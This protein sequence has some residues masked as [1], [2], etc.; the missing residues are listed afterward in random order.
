MKAITFF[1]AFEDFHALKDVCLI[2]DLLNKHGY[3]HYIATSNKVNREKI[4]QIRKM[5]RF[6]SFQI[7]SV[8]STMR[9]KD[10]LILFHETWSTL[11]I[12]L[13]VKIWSFATYKR[14]KVIVKADINSSRVNQ[15]TV[16]KSIR[17]N[18]IVYT[19]DM[20]LYE[21]AKLKPLITAKKNC[22]RTL[23]VI[24]HPPDFANFNGPSLDI[25]RSIK[26]VVII[27]RHGSKQKNSEAILDNINSLPDNIP[28]IFQFI[29]PYTSEF[30]AKVDTENSNSKVQLIGNIS[31]REE[32]KEILQNADYSLH[33]SLWEGFPL[34]STEALL[35]GVCLVGAKNLDFLDLL[36]K[37]NLLSSSHKNIDS[38]FDFIINENIPLIK[39]SNC[40]KKIVEIIEQQNQ[41]IDACLGQL[42]KE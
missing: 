15:T 9:K 20:F 21:N 16:L 14:I 12:A 30:K 40:H 24:N 4:I 11:F 2:G 32:Y 36:N 10:V 19:S 17:L 41:K 29:G 34:A 39:R 5:R 35:S 6:Q 3:D 42:L 23:L 13:F 27:G 25:E 18:L 8:V 26:K 33:F 22:P 37:L 1:P 7:L 31:S 38:E 28:I